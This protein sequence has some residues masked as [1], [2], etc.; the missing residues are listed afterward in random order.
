MAMDHTVG[1][2]VDPST[3]DPAQIETV[4]F[5]PYEASILRAYKKILHRYQLIEALYCSRCWEH[6]LSHGLEAYV[7][8]ERILFRCRCCLRTFSGPTY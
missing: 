6:N 8:N 7:T 5:D 2:I 3:G 4:Q 1:L